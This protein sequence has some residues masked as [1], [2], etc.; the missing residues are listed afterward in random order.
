MRDCSTRR[1]YTDN[2]SRSPPFTNLLSHTLG[3]VS[4]RTDVLW[5]RKRYCGALFRTPVLLVVGAS[6]VLAVVAAPIA[7]HVFRK[8]AVPG[9]PL[10]AYLRAFSFV[11][12][13]ALVRVASNN[14]RV[15]PH[16]SPHGYSSYRTS[17]YVGPR[18]RSDLESHH[19]SLWKS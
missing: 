19:L 18:P 4:N 15:L 11:A 10:V 8:I 6:A 12:P 3:P 5:P 16:A 13:F 2:P 9:E 14:L 7:S 1:T 17:M